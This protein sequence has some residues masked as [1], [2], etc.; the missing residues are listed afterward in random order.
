MAKFTWGLLLVIPLVAGC[1]ETR[2]PP[3]L[4]VLS[5]LPRDAASGPGSPAAARGPVVGVEQANI[6][7]YLDRPEIVV[8]TSA[9]TLELTQ[10]DRWGQRLQGDVTRV[11]ADNLR[12]LL[13]SDNVFVLPLRRREMVAM[14]VGVDITSFER[15]ASGNAVLNAYWTVLD[16][17]T[18]AVRAGARARYVE[19]VEGEG[20][21]A[22]VAAMTRTLASLSRDIAAGIKRAG[23]RK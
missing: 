10:G 21:D 20:A 3:N 14:T 9:N 11:V 22:T 13:P 8:R 12:G 4:H 17:Q 15:D 5:S 7:E 18:E 19:P 2:P 23:S 16:G 6:P 1:A